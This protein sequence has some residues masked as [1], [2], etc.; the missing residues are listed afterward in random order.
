MN[1]KKWRLEGKRAVITGGT[2]GIGFAVADEFVQLGAEIFII[3]RDQALL[4]ERLNSWK[5]QGY[6]VYGMAADVSSKEE[7][8][9]VFKAIKNLWNS[10][11]L[12]VNNVGTNIRKKAIEFTLEEYEKI[13][14]N[15]IKLE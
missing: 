12:L 14:S 13:M 2:K 3:A 8:A 10:F 15:G 1:Q 9:L 6:T 11:H 5:L 7:R 4:D